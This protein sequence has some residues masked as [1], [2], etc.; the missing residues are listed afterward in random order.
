MNVLAF[1]LDH[2]RIVLLH[3]LGNGR[4]DGL[5]QLTDAAGDG[6]GGAHGSGLST[7]RYTYRPLSA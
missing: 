7:P 1:Y 2:G 3:H 4:P 6:W 5:E